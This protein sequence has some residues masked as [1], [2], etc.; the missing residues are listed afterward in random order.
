M[1]PYFK[2]L[3]RLRSFLRSLDGDIMLLIGENTH[4]LVAARKGRSVASVV[5]KNNQLC[6][7]SEFTQDSSKNCGAR[8]CLTCHSICDSNEGL[9]VNGRLLVSG[10]QLNCKSKNVIYLAQCVLC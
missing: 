10:K 2:E 1:V 7:T 5:V 9:R 8:G 3:D 6:A 4:T